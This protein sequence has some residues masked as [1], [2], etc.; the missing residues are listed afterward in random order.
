VNVIRCYLNVTVR[1]KSRDAA[2]NMINGTAEA[3]MI[4]RFDSGCHGLR[5]SFVT[6][7]ITKYRDLD[8]FPNYPCKDTPC[9]KNKKPLNS[10]F[11]W[12]K[13]SKVA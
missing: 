4:C 5:E 11:N 7:T 8:E 6:A 12:R 3:S 2:E 1:E 10:N 9:V 13:Y